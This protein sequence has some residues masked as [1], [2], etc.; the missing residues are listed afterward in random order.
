MAIDTAAPAGPTATLPGEAPGDPV[1]P[2]GGSPPIPE[3]NPD[4][5]DPTPGSPPLIPDVPDEPDPID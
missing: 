5:V 3:P 4:I 1:L 2:G